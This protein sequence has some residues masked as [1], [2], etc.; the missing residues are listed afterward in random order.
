M[1]SEHQVRRNEAFKGLDNSKA[2]DLANYQHFR[3]AQTE[4]KRKLLD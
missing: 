1:T 3:N 4:E 2:L